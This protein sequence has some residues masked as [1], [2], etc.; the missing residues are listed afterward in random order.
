MSVGEV[1]ASTIHANALNM[2][3]DYGVQYPPSVRVPTSELRLV[4]GLSFGLHVIYGEPGPQEGNVIVAVAGGPEDLAKHPQGPLVRMHSACVFS[5]IGDNPALDAWLKQGVQDPSE[6]FG[7][8]PTPSD[9]CDCRAQREAS[10][11]QIAFEGG[12]YLDL[13]EQEGRGWGLDIKRE[14]YRLHREEGLDTAQA[15]DRLGIAF[16]V[17]RYGHCAQ[18]LLATL[19][20]TRVQLMSNNPRKRAA[21]ELA[22]IAVTPVPLVVGVTSTNVDYLRTKRDKGGHELPV[23]L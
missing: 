17:R 13:A 9:E 10:Q 12:V 5:E 4:S 3:F 21:L 2:W 22:G 6:A 15:C 14:I 20:L 11:R 23:D 8:V 7:F 19:G 16:D 1:S 18:F